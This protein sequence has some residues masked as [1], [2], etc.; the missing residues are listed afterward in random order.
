MGLRPRWCSTMWHRRQVVHLANRIY[1]TLESY[2][3]SSCFLD[4]HVSKPFCLRGIPCCLFLRVMQYPG[5]VFQTFSN[6][7]FLGSPISWNDHSNKLHFCIFGEEHTKYSC[8]SILCFY[9]IYHSAD[10]ISVIG[11][12]L[13][14]RLGFETWEVFAVNSPLSTL[15]QKSIM[16]SKQKSICDLKKKKLKWVQVCLFLFPRVVCFIFQNAV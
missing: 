4:L 7:L 14:E 9:L 1:H 13:S 8:C 2:K 16:F 5:W 6:T 10:V 15:L 11:L 3:A 12:Y